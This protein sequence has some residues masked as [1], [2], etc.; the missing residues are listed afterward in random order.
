M[1]CFTAVPYQGEA[2]VK[3]CVYNKE[4]LIQ[5]SQIE[6]LRIQPRCNEVLSYSTIP[7]AVLYYS[8]IPGRLGRAGV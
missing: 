3:R 7:K 2:A 8:T 4:M 5:P 1:Q 6:M